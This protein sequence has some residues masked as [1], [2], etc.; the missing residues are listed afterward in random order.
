MGKK[1]KMLK[2]GQ[3][4]SMSG[5]VVTLTADH[6]AAAATA[7]DPAV[8]A[9]PLVVGHPAVDSPSYGALAAVDFTAPF[10]N[11]EPGRIAPEF[12]KVVNDGYYDHVS[13][14]LFEPD[15][16]AN[17]KPGVYYP[18]HLG[19]LG[20]A[21]P[22]VPGLG[23][24]SFAGDDAGVVSFSIPLDSV[25]FG[26]YADTVLVRVLRSLKN[27]L[28]GEMGKEKADAA[29]DEWDLQML[30]EEAARPEPPVDTP[31]PA[32]AEHNKGG[33]SMK[34]T[35]E[36]T[37]ALQQ[38]NETLKASLKASA[39][40]AAHSANLA[41]A[42]GLVKEG[43]LL[44]AN[45]AKIVAVLDFAATLEDGN[46]IEFSE[47]TTTKTAAVADTLK[48]VLS[49]YPKIIEFGELAGGEGPEGQGKET[50]IPAKI[51]DCV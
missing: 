5:K 47:G 24:V 17:P 18:R 34:L 43:K 36:E 28:I 33:A 44:P 1:I 35:E 6:L 39:I 12:V 23:T 9:C 37:A 21:A 13:L 14:S 46:T 48:E 29:I 31:E 49:S 10:L 27:T 11:G 38:E 51:T 26:S 19:F 8:Y 2:P 16:P 22:A 32:F 40:G 30:T 7:Y 4:K 41:F 45:Q 42:D 25:A 50:V 15:S 20:A 3:F